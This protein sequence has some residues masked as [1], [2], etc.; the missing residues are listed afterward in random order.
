MEL[1]REQ[2]DW[3][4]SSDLSRAHETAVNILAK[5]ES[6]KGI[7]IEKDPLLRERCFG[8][9]EDK[10]IQECVDAASAAGAKSFYEFVPEGAETE[11]QVQ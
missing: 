9:Y 6:S 1:R 3:V 11:A 10:P 2:F 5:N 4:I 8:V 7:S